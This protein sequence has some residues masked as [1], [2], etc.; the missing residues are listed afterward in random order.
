MVD[1]R[2][3]AAAGQKRRRQRGQPRQQNEP[4]LIVARRPGAP[5]P[6]RP[7]AEPRRV[8]AFSSAPPPK[9]EP[10]AP[11][12]LAEPA[13]RRSARIVQSS[14]Q[15]SG[16]AARERQRLL[17]RLM[18]SDGRIAITRA[19]RD[20][21]QAGFEFPLEQGV[22]LQLLEHIDES[23]A[24]SA[25]HALSRLI[26]AEAPLK[27]PVLEQRLRRLEEYAED[28]QTREAA[29]TLRRALRGRGDPT[30]EPDP[31]DSERATN[32]AVEH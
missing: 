2:Q 17:E 13:P 20:Y 10:P 24:L 16:D 25:I 12:P 8:L 3:R 9:P 1:K 22:M 14:P 28:G 29:A 15:A 7:E 30:S 32:G 26:G 6:R 5:S 27:R 19:A 18:A 21:R 4:I 11:A 23:L 31:A